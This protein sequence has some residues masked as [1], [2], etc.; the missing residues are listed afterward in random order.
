MVLPFYSWIR[1]LVLSYMVLPQTQGAKLLYSNYI[2]P[3]IERHEH[4]IEVF[5]SDAHERAASAGLSYMK[6]FIDL[7]REKVLGLPP[8]QAAQ[9]PPPQTYGDAAAAYATNLLSRFSIPQARVAA[10]PTAPSDLYSLLSSALSSAA[11]SSSKSA[12]TISPESLSSPAEKLSFLTAQRERLVQLLSVVDHEKSSLTTEKS[13]EAD[14]ESRMQALD[15]TAA[16]VG[17]NLERNRNKSEHSFENI[18]REEYS[19]GESGVRKAVDAPKS[20]RTVSSGWV[21]TWLGGVT[22]ATADKPD[23]TA[24]KDRRAA[25]ESEEPKG[26]SSGFELGS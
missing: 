18:E 20:R 19:E 9:P 10:V 3:F 6:K 4:D 5:I 2:S 12:T 8:P 17:N 23:T 22:T 14:I 1:L 13:I 24:T 21:P 15:P 26:V 25:E 16:I 11:P 7:V